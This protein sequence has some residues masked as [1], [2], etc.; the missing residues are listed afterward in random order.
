MKTNASILV[1]ILVAFIAPALSSAQA[2][3]PPPAAPTGT[4][5]PA[6]RI[7]DPLAPR[8]KVALFTLR[9]ETNGTYV[10]KSAEGFPVQDGDIVRLRPEIAR[11]TWSWDAAKREFQL[12]PGDFVFYIKR[13]LVDQQHTNRLA[14]G[15]SWLVREEN[16]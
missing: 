10:A 16:K 12:E 5:T 1:V 6:F 9:L 2:T 11:G 13:L 4:Y 8:N 15:K 3:E 7:T 14:W